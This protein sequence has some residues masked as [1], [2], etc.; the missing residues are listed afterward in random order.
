MTSAP[1]DDTVQR[2]TFLHACLECTLFDIVPASYFCLGTRVSVSEAQTSQQH[3][4][5]VHNTH[6]AVKHA[7]GI[8]II[9]LAIPAQLSPASPHIKPDVSPIFFI[10]AAM[11]IAAI[12]WNPFITG[13]LVYACGDLSLYSLL[14]PRKG[15]TRHSSAEGVGAPRGGFP[16]PC[17]VVH[18]LG[19]THQMLSKHPVALAF[20]AHPRRIYMASGSAIFFADVRYFV[21]VCT[22]SFDA[23][24]LVI[25]RLHD[26]HLRACLHVHPALTSEW[27]PYSKQT[28]TC[29]GNASALLS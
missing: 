23:A 19:N 22:L 7:L 24:V 13:E 9:D 15:D 6:V 17:P 21:C 16:Q 26:Q 4:T 25:V 8:S 1:D 5:P 29:C 10:P 18:A 12:L 14:L 11:Q 2:Q 3:P 20:V 27:C 28:D